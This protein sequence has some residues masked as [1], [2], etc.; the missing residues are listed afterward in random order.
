MK[1]DKKLT[2]F[3]HKT[4]DNFILNITEKPRKPYGPGVLLRLDTECT[5]DTHFIYDM[6]VILAMHYF[7]FATLHLSRDIRLIN[8]PN[9]ALV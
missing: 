8:P 6:R 1:L 7:D 3:F 2:L 9:N 5:P 4:N